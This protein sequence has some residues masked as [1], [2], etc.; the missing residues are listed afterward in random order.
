MLTNFSP[1]AE[2]IISIILG[3][4]QGV[5]E[6]LP[7]SSTAHLLIFSKYITAREISLAASNVIQFGTFIAILQYFKEDISI[8][9]KHLWTKIRSF[10]EIKLTFTNIK[11]WIKDPNQIFDVHAK[12]DIILSQ[13][14][15]A[16][17]PLIVMALTLRK[18]LEGLRS[19][20]NYIA[21]FL[22]LGGI[23]IVYSELMHIK[24]LNIKKS[25]MMSLKETIMIGLFQSLA[26]FP[27]VSR[28]GSALAG[29]LFLGRNRAESVRFSFLLSIPALGLASIYD[30]ISVSKDFVN[31]KVT[32]L[33]TLSS[34]ESEKLNLSLLSIFIAFVVSYI[35]GLLTLKF[36]LKYLATNDSKVF[37]LYR[38]LLVIFILTTVSVTLKAP[39]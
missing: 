16:T 39:L 20:L 2:Y 7:I 19:E 22:T 9:F 30:L 8:L 29:G 1:I 13:L 26:V 27:G 12:Q 3:I 14:I 6:F 33:P 38:I 18:F 21:I 32:L 37:I 24:K 36:L 4:V 23:L 10:K 17:V 28:S 34:W 25:K 11:S 31:K 15:I 5:T 35:V